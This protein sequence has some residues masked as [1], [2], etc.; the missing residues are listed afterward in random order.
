MNLPLMSLEVH[1]LCKHLKLQNY[2]INDM[3][4]G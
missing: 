3:R 4:S 2:E 1:G